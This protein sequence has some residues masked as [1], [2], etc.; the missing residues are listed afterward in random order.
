LSFLIAFLTRVRLNAHF[1]SESKATITGPQAVSTI[2]P[3][4]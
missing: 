2:L 1:P 4:A 3:M